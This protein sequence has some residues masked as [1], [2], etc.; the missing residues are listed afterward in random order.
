MANWKWME[1]FMGKEEAYEDEDVEYS[2]ESYAE[3]PRAAAPEAPRQTS[4]ISGSSSAALEMKIVKPEKFEDVKGIANHL[5][6][7]RTVVLNLENTNK[8]TVRRIL[9]FLAGTT[10][11]IEGHIQ[12]AAN[13]TYIITPKNVEVSADLEQAP[14][15]KK[16]LY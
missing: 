10:Y 5:L 11:A 3:A 1:K 14:A 6:E 9:D 8:E 13:S 15:A 7:R 4:A 12:R 2:E 16:E